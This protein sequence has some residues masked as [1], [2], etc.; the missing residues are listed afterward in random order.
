M[1]SLLRGAALS[2]NRDSRRRLRQL[3]GKDRVASDILGL[4]AALPYT[5]HD[6]IF[7]QRRID[8]RS[9]DQPSRCEVSMS[10]ATAATHGRNFT[11]VETQ[12]TGRVASVHRLSIKSGH[13]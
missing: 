9:L 5:P 13:C 10:S 12:Q 8:P 3:R 6:H 7:D 2:F 4:L 11:G 1:Q